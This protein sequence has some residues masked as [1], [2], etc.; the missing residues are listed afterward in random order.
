M[1]VSAGL[2]VCEEDSRPTTPA[3]EID[4]DATACEIEVRAANSELEGV[5]VAEGAA[6]NEDCGLKIE[7][8]G[9]DACEKDATIPGL[10]V[11]VGRRGIDSDADST[12]DALDKTSLIACGVA[13]ASAC[14]TLDAT[15]SESTP[16]GNDV[17]AG[18][19]WS[20]EACADTSSAG[21]LEDSPDPG[22][23]SPVGFAPV[24]CP[25]LDIC[26]NIV[27]GSLAGNGSGCEIEVSGAGEAVDIGAEIAA[28]IDCESIVEAADGTGDSVL[29]IEDGPTGILPISP[30]SCPSKP[31][32]PPCWLASVELENGEAI[33][34]CVYYLLDRAKR[35]NDCIAHL[36]DRWL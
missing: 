13:A 33:L 15:G 1:L 7:D 35:K 10:E 25:S 14:A 30:T 21:R 31:A 17:C 36:L 29:R 32:L 16:A 20:S 9:D 2:D 23:G 24:T 22:A 11:E 8:T 28:D 27:A 6:C 19:C 4:G 5:A 12:L 18:S 26:D 3:A 34:T